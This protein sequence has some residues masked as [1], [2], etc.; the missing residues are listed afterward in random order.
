[1]RLSAKQFFNGLC[2]FTEMNGRAV[3][4]EYEKRVIA[5]TLRSDVR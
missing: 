4:A 5:H 3:L 2:D 1:M